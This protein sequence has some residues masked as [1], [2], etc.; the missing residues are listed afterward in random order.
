M[1][2]AEAG[3][4]GPGLSRRLQLCAAR[5]LGCAAGPI[6]PAVL[7]VSQTLTRL[8]PCHSGRPRE[9]TMNLSCESL[10]HTPKNKPAESR[11]SPRQAQKPAACCP[12]TPHIPDRVHPWLDEDVPEHRRQLQDEA[13]Q[14]HLLPVKPPGWL[15]GAQG[16]CGF[17]PASPR[18]CRQASIFYGPQSR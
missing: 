10:S 7:G 8:C 5:T 6:F 2:V 18:S 15:V 3:R 4:P 9:V 13:T 12:H 17:L 14:S 16:G 1:R 11:P